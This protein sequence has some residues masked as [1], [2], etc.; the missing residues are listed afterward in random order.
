MAAELGVEVDCGVWQGGCGVFVGGGIVGC[1]RGLFS[2]L[3]IFRGVTVG[4]VGV[5]GLI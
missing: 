3:G 4:I 2:G 5:V 1:G